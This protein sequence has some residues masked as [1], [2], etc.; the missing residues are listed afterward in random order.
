MPQSLPG[1]SDHSSFSNEIV[2]NFLN[3]LTQ[4]FSK[5]FIEGTI[6]TSRALIPILRDNPVARVGYF[7]AYTVLVIFL[8]QMMARFFQEKVIR[9]LFREK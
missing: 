9:P 1:Y 5:S 2:G 6:E 4:I 8:T 7:L 3:N